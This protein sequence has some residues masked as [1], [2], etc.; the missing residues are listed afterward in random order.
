M[1]LPVLAVSAYVITSRELVREIGSLCTPVGTF[2][3]SRPARPGLI[4]MIYQHVMMQGIFGNLSA[5][6]CSIA[7]MVSLLC[8][9]YY[10]A[11][12]TDS[13]P[14]TYR[15]RGLPGNAITRPALLPTDMH[16]TDWILFHAAQEGLEPSASRTKIW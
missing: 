15:L 6:L 14:L 2:C 1:N 8:C 4:L 7:M 13:N 5:I 9:H 16:L 11:F 3:R 10:I 12:K